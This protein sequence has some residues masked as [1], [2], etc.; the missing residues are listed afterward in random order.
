MIYHYAYIYDDFA[1][2]AVYFDSF[3]A[4]INFVLLSLLSG[5]INEH[6]F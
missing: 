2:A 5:K 6:Y 3:Y 4:L 1:L